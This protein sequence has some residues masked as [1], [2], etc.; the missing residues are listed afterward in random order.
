MTSAVPVILECTAP[1]G[2]WPFSRRES[3]AALSNKGRN[4]PN[5][6]VGKQ[7]TPPG[8]F[9]IDRGAAALG[10]PLSWFPCS[11]LPSGVSSSRSSK[12]SNAPADNTGASYLGRSAG[13][14]GNLLAPPEISVHAALTDQNS[15][16]S[17]SL[18]ES[19]RV[20]DIYGLADMRGN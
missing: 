14:P 19:S 6:R 9:I 20:C 7:S 2:P 13:S 11:W 8:P 15:H 10:S 1:L 4:T 17:P 5:Q 12:G 3:Y 16:K 18:A